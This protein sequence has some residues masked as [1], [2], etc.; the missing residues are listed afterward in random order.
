MIEDLTQA[1]I[2]ILSAGYLVLL[3]TSGKL[4]YHLLRYISGGTINQKVGKEAR[5]TGFVIGKCENLLVLTFMLVDAYTALSLI[6]AGKA[7]VREKDIRK[8]SLF[9]LTGMMVNITYSVMIGL[10]MKIIINIY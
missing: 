4:V 8:D 5:D 9:Y 6:F 3:A 10:V 2:A 1:D 7:V